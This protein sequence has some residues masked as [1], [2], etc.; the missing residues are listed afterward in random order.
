MIQVDHVVVVLSK[1]SHS[2]KNTVQNP[3]SVRRRQDQSGLGLLT[4]LL[5][6]HLLVV[7]SDLT[8][9]AD[10]EDIVIE[11]D[12]DAMVSD[13][14]FPTLDELIEEEERGT[15]ALVVRD[16]VIFIILADIPPT[17]ADSNSVV[18][19]FY[20]GEGMSDRVL[21]SPYYGLDLSED[22]VSQGTE[23]LAVHHFPKSPSA[24]STYQFPFFEFQRPEALVAAGRAC[25]S[26]VAPS[27]IDSQRV[28]RSI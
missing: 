1:E 25:R 2:L 14:S 28:A 20:I 17:D 26:R 8:S 21:V 6:A 12:R 24:D 5:H 11:S 9:L 3:F 22:L 4:E 10:G 27:R 13:L 16:E 19:L 7:I 23:S 15:D 18:G